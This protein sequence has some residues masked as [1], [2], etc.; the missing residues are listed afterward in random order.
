MKKFLSLFLIYILL[1]SFYFNST[2]IDS[3]YSQ[4][5]DKGGYSD[6]INFIRF[7]NEN[8]AYQEVSNGN[9]DLYLFQ[10]PLQLVDIAK[11]N[12]NLNLYEKEGMSY[13]LLLN[14]SSNNF[15]FNPFSL[16]EVRYALNFLIDRN[17]IINDVLKGFGI[18]IVEPYGPTSPEYLNILDV[19][20][21]LAIRHDPTYASNII[22]NAL[23]KVGAKIDE[24]GHYIING[25]P[26]VLK[27]LI[28]NDDLIRKT[29]GDIVASELERAGFIVVKEYGD[30]TKANRVVYGSNP[31]DLEWHIYTESF[32]SNSFS[33][34]NPST[35]GQMY[36]PWFGN[37]PGSQNPI[38]WQYSNS[39][40]DG[41]TQKLIFN[42]YTTESERNDLLKEAN[43]MG[44][45]EAVRLFFA[46]AYEPYIA[47]SN[48]QGLINDYSAG[49][50][51]E[52]AIKNAQ[53]NIT[54][55]NNTLDIGM[56]QIFQGAWNNV[57]GCVDFYCRIIYSLINDDALIL[58]PY[59]GD[60][61]P[62]RNKWKQVISDGPTDRLNVSSSSIVWNPYSQKWDNIKDSDN[63]SS[64][65]TKITM[66]PL[67]SHWHNGQLM[68]KYDLLYSYYFPFEWSIQTGSDD[69]TF[70]AEYS[71]LI[72]PTL[73]L[74]KG[75][76][77][78]ENGTFDSYI[79]IWH[80]D[81]NQIPL[82]GSLWAS[83]PWEI[84]AATER[85]VS[86]NK[87]SYSKTDSNIKQLEQLSLNFP[88]HADLIKQE[89]IKMTKEQYIPQPLKGKVTLDYVL[90]R[91]NSSINWI[92]NHHN[93]VIG[94]GPYFLNSFNPSG[95]IVNLQKFNDDIYPINTVDFSKYENPPI[96][97]VKSI[98]IPK[99]IKIGKPL[100][101]ELVVNSQQY[102]N[103]S[104]S[105]VGSIHYFISD[106]NN[107]VVVKDNN[108]ELNNNTENMNKTNGTKTNFTEKITITLNSTET[109]KLI[110]GPA[111]IKLIITAKDSPKPIIK[112][113]NL[114]ARP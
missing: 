62:F 87:F 90:Q 51:N 38:F 81:Q 27:I 54:D 112:E 108:V 93:A 50:A 4:D 52:L 111:K 92:N 21:P 68:D 30:L 40:I 14:P 48:I 66:Q 17:L 79:D 69:K 19:A 16:K 39:T 22:N 76:D 94:N 103:K 43:L 33:R 64:A 102:G 2:D 15:T 49:I 80:Y 60:P 98:D 96:F 11:S 37:M 26:V 42:N 35:V 13:G 23:T 63:N 3:I 56:K 74:I 78:Y 28:R 71:S 97:E 107:D 114:I 100:N 45:Q 75:I 34:Y 95:G 24:N 72:E 91:Y 83:E 36:A 99:F 7:T 61:E 55:G 70:D 73:S 101:F 58:N 53:N 29:F 25:K 31:L 6:A 110:P 109:E 59:S 57:K 32:I 113:H 20:E 84:T 106:R 88:T 82:Y 85:L 41:I 5:S 86:Q 10:I 104:E 65:L 1:L 47:S 89:L 9:L 67:F 44:I 46:R 77:F 18:P 12:P 105:S 8:V